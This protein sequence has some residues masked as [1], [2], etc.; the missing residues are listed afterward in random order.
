MTTETSGTATKPKDRVQEMAERFARETSDH[1]LTIALDDGMYR[2]LRFRKPGTGLYWFD[3]VTWP[4][5][6]VINGDCGTYVFSRIDDMFEFFRRAD[7]SIN[8]QYWAEK[9]S[10]AGRSAK[11]YS[12]QVFRARLEEALADYECEYPVQ[13]E[14]VDKARTVI[15]E[16][17]ELA[18]LGYEDNARD[19]L[20]ELERHTVVVGDLTWEWDLSDWDWQY[21]W[22]CHA[23]VWGIA[24]YDAAKAGA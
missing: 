3:L 7:G 12:E 18:D 14:D 21:L 15:A 10:D 1:E 23:I 9:L 16:H 4:G 11:A 24:Q 19:L 22:C 17:E 8:P 20:N 6:L 13:T 2:H 5:I